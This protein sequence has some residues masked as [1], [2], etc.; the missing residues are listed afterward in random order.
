MKRPNFVTRVRVEGILCLNV[1]R[2]DGTLR[3]YTGEFKNLILDNGL[4]RMGVGTFMSHCQVGSGST[5]PANTDTALV[6]YVAATNSLHAQTQGTALATPYYGYTR[7]TFRFSAGTATGNLTEVGIGWQSATGNLFSRS[8]IKDELGDPTTI[9]VLSDEVLDVVYELRSYV[10]EVDSAS[11]EVTVT[12]DTPVTYDCFVRA[13][14]VTDFQ[15]WSPNDGAVSYKSWVSWLIAGHT[16]TVGAIT[17]SPNGTAGGVSSVV[18][19]AYGNNDL[20]RDF[21]MIWELDYGNVSGGIR[22]IS[23]TSTIGAWQAQFDP[24]TIPKTSVRVLHINVRVAWDRY[25]P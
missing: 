9:T 14:R 4:N 20:Y 1:Y 17:S 8:L 11:F 12:G 6:T 5:P 21:D 23:F 10:D 22:S 16:G 7:K 3:V 15:Y 25:V 24:T 13:M 18:A 19:A 2:P